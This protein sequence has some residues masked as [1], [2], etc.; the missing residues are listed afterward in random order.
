LIV[1]VFNGISFADRRYLNS[2]K[3]EEYFAHRKMCKPPNAMTHRECEIFVFVR[4]GI[5]GLTV[6]GYF[7]SLNDSRSVDH[8][9]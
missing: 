7:L 1:E 9:H 5:G 3:N 8:D 6:L 2:R 4:F